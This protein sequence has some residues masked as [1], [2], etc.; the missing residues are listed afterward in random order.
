MSFDQSRMLDEVSSSLLDDDQSVPKSH[1]PGEGF[2]K[3]T[4]VA[5]VQPDGGS[6]GA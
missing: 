1:Q 3:T 6:S 2:D 5:L 4:V